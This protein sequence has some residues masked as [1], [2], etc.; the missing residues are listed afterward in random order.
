MFDGLLKSKFYTKCKSQMKM[1]KARLEMLKKKK[2]SVAKFLKDDMADLLRSGLDYNAYCRAEGL[3]V[4]QKMLACFNF[5]EQFCGCISSNLS[6]MNK[7]RE[8]PE[9]CREA[10]QSLIY[11]A[12]RI[13]EFPELR[14]LRTLLTERYGSHL[15]S[16]INKQFVETLTPTPTTKEMKLLLMHEIAEEFNIEW[17]SKSLEQKIFKPP[18]EDQNIHCPKSNDDIVPKGDCQDDDENGNKRK[19]NKE[20]LTKRTNHETELAS[21]RRKNAIDKGYNLPCSGE[22]EV[23]SL[24]RRDSSDLDSLQATSS[25]AGSVSE[26]EVDSKKPFYRFVNPPYVKP[27]VEKEESKIE[28]PPKLTGNVLAE[29]DLVSEANPKTRSVR[30]RPL[31]PPP[32]HEDVGIVER[33]LKAPTGLEKFVS[34]GNGGL[35]KANSSAVLK[36]DGAK[37]G[38]RISQ[39]DEVDQ[40]D[41]E[42]EMI[43]G[44]LMHYSKD[45]VKPYLKPPPNI[46]GTKSE[47]PLPPG[48]E[49]YQAAAASP[50]KAAKR[51]NRVVSLQPETGHVHPN[52]PDYEDLAAWFAALKSR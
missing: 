3:L 18:Q 26:D 35:A 17:N 6:A 14:D 27:K 8:C 48:G 28:E 44:L 50:K 4:E 47:S 12:A 23:F 20:D 37:R 36:E 33:P 42:E 5:V 10:V 11:A 38:S 15:E 52:L 16:F 40:K 39:A 24:H 32:G 21:H 45:S 34:P 29:D 2:S 1:T 49:V 43:D 25:S 41:E 22:D 13:A 7:Q 31:K 46:R 51:H 19:K 30:R 9:E